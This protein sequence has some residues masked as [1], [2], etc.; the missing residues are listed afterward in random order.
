MKR[1]LTE[2]K[3]W[4][5]DEGIAKDLFGETEKQK[6]DSQYKMPPG[7]GSPSMFQEISV[8]GREWI[9]RR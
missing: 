7:R 6:R 8:P 4:A 5:N 3:F 1:N 9:Q 2:K